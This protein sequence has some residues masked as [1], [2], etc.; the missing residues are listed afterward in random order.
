MSGQ[1]AIRDSH[2]A[3]TGKTV[4]SGSHC[5]SHTLFLDC[6]FLFLAGIPELQYYVHRRT[7][8]NVAQSKG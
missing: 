5:T 6:P 8:V 3:D 2:S 1:L 7:E 4:A